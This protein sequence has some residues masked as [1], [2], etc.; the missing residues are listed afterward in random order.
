[1]DY[2]ELKDCQ[3]TKEYNSEKDVKF[4]T[5]KDFSSLYFKD[6]YFAIYFPQDAHRPSLTYK[7]EEQVVKAVFKIKA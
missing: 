4:L 5:A 3:I 7:T 1:M 2:A 6:G